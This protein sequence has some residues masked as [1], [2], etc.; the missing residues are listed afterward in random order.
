MLLVRISHYEFCPKE[1]VGS[2]V[3]T[4]AKWAQSVVLT[5]KYAVLFIFHFTL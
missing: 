1:V 3:V 5:Q 2:K 4:S